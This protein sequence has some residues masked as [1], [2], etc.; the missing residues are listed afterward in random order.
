[1]YWIGSI[2]TTPSD[3]QL[4]PTEGKEVDQIIKPEKI[5][6]LRKLHTNFFVL[7][8][9]TDDL[10]NSTKIYF[11]GYCVIATF[12]HVNSYPWT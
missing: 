7:E 11:L 5:E 4:I 3:D 9:P 10:G 2:V 1:M 6:N 8:G 12:L